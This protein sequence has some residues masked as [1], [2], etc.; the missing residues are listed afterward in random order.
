VGS[1][2]G[3]SPCPFVERIGGGEGREEGETGGDCSM[4][5]VPKG[6]K[7]FHDITMSGS[8]KPCNPRFGYRY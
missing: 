8:D 3:V 4:K 5:A 7:L 1:R 6:T 2:D